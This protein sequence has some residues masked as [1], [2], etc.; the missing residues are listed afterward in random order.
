MRLR[1]SKELR[2]LVVKQAGI[3]GMG[4]AFMG[5]GTVGGGGGGGSGKREEM[6]LGRKDIDIGLIA[7]AAT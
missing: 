6:N 4:L 7:F 2:K 3:Q 5:W 1:D